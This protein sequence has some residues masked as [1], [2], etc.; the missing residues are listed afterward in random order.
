MA[1]RIYSIT[2]PKSNP[3]G[4]RIEL[5]IIRKQLQYEYLLNVFYKL[6]ANS[7]HF[8]GTTG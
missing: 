2:V 4:K 3:A 5:Q 7:S 6:S 1:P 8:K